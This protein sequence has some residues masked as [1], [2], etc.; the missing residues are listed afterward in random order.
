METTLP[1]LK[2]KITLQEAL[3][4][5]DDIVQNLSYPEKRAIFWLYLDRHRAQIAEVVSRHLNIPQAGLRLGELGDWI[6]GSFNVCIPVHI[7]RPRPHLPRQAIIRIPLPYRAGEEHYP[8]NVDEKLRCEAATYIW[9]QRNCPAVPIPRLLGFGFPGTQ[10]F[11]ALENEPFYIRILWYLRNAIP[12]ISGHTLS[13][14]FPH[15]RRNLLE[16]GYLLIEHVD[17]GNM[18]SESWKERRGDQDRRANL[19]RH[20]S[21]IMLSLARVPLP[22]I[23]SWTVD[24]RGLLS[25]TNR[26]LTFQLHQLENRQIP[27]HIPRDLTYTSVEPYYLDILACHD[28]RIRHQPNSIHHQG[29]GEAQLA[30]LTTMRA[31]LPKFTSRRLRGG[32]F[33]LTLT[34]LHQSNI[35][36]DNDWHITRLIDLEWACVRPIEMLSPP[37]WLSSPSTGESALG[38]DELVGDELDEYAQAHREFMDAFETEELAQR[39][40]GEYTR[41]IRECWET[42]SFWYSQALDCPSALYAIFMFHIQ[43]KFA[44][45]GNAALDE[46]S[47]WVMPYWDREAANFLA[48]KVKQQGEYSNQIREAFAAVSLNLSNKGE[49]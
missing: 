38:I 32:P 46:F 35:F 47:R 37:W 31:L 44:D 3:E 45:L 17:E 20:L 8:G 19:F 41:I 6:H 33:V 16:H 2:G 14:Y 25:L 39:Q 42:G 43:P 48:S 36:V 5:D 13:P 29:D 24:N 27:T 40:S 26:P 22:R 23:G 4:E 12:W 21:R 15:P 11:T 10:S 7:T 34:D 9:L 18:L 49:A 1:L 30:A 28:S